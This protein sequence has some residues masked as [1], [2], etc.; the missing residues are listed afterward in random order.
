MN[1]Q[2][3]FNLK[4][5]GKLISFNRY[6]KTRVL[7]KKDGK[8]IAIMYA[9][10]EYNN[11]VKSLIQEIKLIWNKEPITDYVDMILKTSRWKMADTGNVEKPIGDSLE[12]A[13]VIKNDNLIRHYFILREYHKKGEDDSL[14]IILLPVGDNKRLIQVLNDCLDN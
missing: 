7:R 13:G 6:L 4:W 14:E 10:T 11:L 9:S 2:Y 1:E 5:T 3:L 12:K 8:N